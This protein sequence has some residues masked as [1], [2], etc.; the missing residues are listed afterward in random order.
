[1]GTLVAV[2]KEGQVCI[3]TNASNLREPWIRGALHSTPHCILKVGESYVGLASSVAYQQAFEHA[4]ASLNPR[5]IPSL[6]SRQEI[7]SFF[8]SLH[9]TL[10]N[11][12]GMNVAYQSNQEFEWSPMNAIIANRSGLY[13]VDSSR[14]VYEFTSYW[15]YGAAESF[16]LGALY[17]TYPISEFSAQ[18]IAVKS[19]EAASQFDSVATGDIITFV[20]QSPTLVMTTSYDTPRPRRDRSKT[21]KLPQRTRGT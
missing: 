11:S 12:S 6:A 9:E 18:D 14:G 20:L 2:R 5:R 10:R 8:T 13:R 4:I 19:L 7:Y 21:I 16:A 1:M 15:A 17:A 3:G